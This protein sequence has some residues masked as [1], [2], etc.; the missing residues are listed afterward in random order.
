MRLIWLLVLSLLAPAAL[1]AAVAVK[2][3]L[4]DLAEHA[5]VVVH[6]TVKS[7][8]SRWDAA[9]RGIWTH[10]TIDVAETFKGEHQAAREFVTRGGVVGDIGQHVAG[11]GN[12]A[13]GEEYVLFLWR[14]AEDR[15]QLV[16]MVQGAL[17]V[18]GEGDERRAR[19]SFRGLTLV[20][21]TTLQPTPEAANAPINVTL[22]DL[23]EH[24]KPAP[25]AKEQE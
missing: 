17:K 11:S 4:D 23:R 10:H 25:P 12:F 9:Q 13:A 16:G 24:L 18:S 1:H 21:P 2:L 14:D 7:N 15:L 5:D 6:A 8:E 20:D 22:S 19:N 3:S